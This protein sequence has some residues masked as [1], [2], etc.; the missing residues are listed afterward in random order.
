MTGTKIDQKEAWNINLPSQG[1][2]NGLFQVPVPT[3]AP[4]G[5]VPQRS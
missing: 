2:M 3:L 1:V 4:V 5:G